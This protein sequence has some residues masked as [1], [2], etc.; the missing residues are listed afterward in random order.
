MKSVQG[1]RNIGKSLETLCR[2][3]YIENMLLKNAEYERKN[4][5]FRLSDDLGFFKEKGLKQIQMIK[6]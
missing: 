2:R 4:N 6:D 1:S 3:T 5:F